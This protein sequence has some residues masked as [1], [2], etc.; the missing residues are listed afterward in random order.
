MPECM[1]VLKY[2]IPCYICFSGIKLF[3]VL[4]DA[5]KY[6]WVLE[7]CRLESR[8]EYSQHLI[9]IRAHS[10]NGWAALYSH[11]VHFVQHLQRLY[12]H[13]SLPDAFILHT[14]QDPPIS[15]NDLVLDKYRQVGSES[16]FFGRW[17]RGLQICATEER[18]LGCKTSNWNLAMDRFALTGAHSQHATKHY[19]V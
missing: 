11:Y 8:C 17:R 16:G 4:P 9:C 18:V 6:S 13:P 14:R 19:T 3:P 10:L 12:H 5:L 1:L 2:C 15:E 7:H